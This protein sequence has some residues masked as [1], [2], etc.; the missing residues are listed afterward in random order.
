MNGRSE[1]PQIGEAAALARKHLPGYEKKVRP[2]RAALE[3]RIL[4]FNSNSEL[5]TSG[6][7]NFP[8]NKSL[9]SRVEPL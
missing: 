8:C 4:K 5:N 6:R 3:E 1:T 7:G 9:A 2:L